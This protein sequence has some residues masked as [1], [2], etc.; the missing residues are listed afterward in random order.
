MALPRHNTTQNAI[1]VNR[2]NF[3]ERDSNEVSQFL[4]EK[5]Q[6]MG[7]VIDTEVNGMANM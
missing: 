3:L 7:T 2:H 1:N 5:R 4:G 6:F